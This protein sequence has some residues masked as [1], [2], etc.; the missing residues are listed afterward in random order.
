MDM[1]LTWFRVRVNANIAHHEVDLAVRL[2]QFPH[3]GLMKVRRIGRVG[4]AMYGPAGHDS[5]TVRSVIGLSDSRP[6]PHPGWVDGYA[7]RHGIPIVARL[8]EYYMRQEAIA[9]RLGSLAAALLCWRHRSQ[10]SAPDQS[11]SKNSRKMLFCC[12]TTKRRRQPVLGQWPL[13][14]PRYSD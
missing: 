11:L 9:C 3:D 12:S 2:R 1:K 13:L 7:R 6:P 8:G 14:L 10:A 4:F 5:G